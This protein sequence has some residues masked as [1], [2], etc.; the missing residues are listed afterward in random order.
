V[1]IKKPPFWSGFRNECGKYVEG[2]SKSAN[3]GVAGANDSK[4]TIGFV[5]SSSN[6]ATAGFSKELYN[7]EITFRG[8]TIVTG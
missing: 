4:S 7:F 6:E 1:H 8:G 5:N 2:Y 3:N